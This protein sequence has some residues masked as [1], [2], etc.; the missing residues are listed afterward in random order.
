[1]RVA[2]T[3]KKSVRKSEILSLLRENESMSIIELAKVVQVSLS[4]VRRDLDEL[5]EEGLIKRKF[6]SAE[7]LS[8][9][10]REPSFALRATYCEEE[11][12]RIARAALDL[13]ENNETVFITGG[14][15]TLEFARLLPGQRRLTVITH[16]LRVANLLVDRPGIELMILGGA[17]LP[18][19]E[20]THGHLTEWGAQQ[21]RADKLIYGIQ[22]VSLRHGLTYSQVVEVSTDRAIA[23]IVNQVILLA[24]HT[25][26]GK[27]APISVMPVTDV[28]V[29]VTGRELDR[30][31]VSEL[32]AV[33]VRVVQA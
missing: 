7:I 15:T 17:V 10:G 9:V 12:Q 4:T 14:S 6:G 11:K 5:M 31:M 22:A 23:K 13:V 27:V 20:T 3:K 25:K 2:G 8:S 19:E 18:D 16:S 26:F 28:H 30:Q 33:G 29:I 24:D 21:F 32:E 1:M